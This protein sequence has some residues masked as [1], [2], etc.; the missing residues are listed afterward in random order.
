[1]EKVAQT[2]I[3]FKILLSL[4]CSGALPAELVL[5]DFESDADLDRIHWGC[6]SL[7]SLSEKHA[8]SGARSLEMKL[9]PA[10]Y[11]GLA[12]KLAEND[13][14]RYGQVAL[15]IFNPQDETL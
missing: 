15:D 11:P 2:N 6:R 14:S 8:T 12:L 13:W 5:N 3:G 4:G 7:F 1:V 9:F 10:A